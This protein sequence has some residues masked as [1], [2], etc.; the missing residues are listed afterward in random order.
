[1]DAFMTSHIEKLVVK[2]GLV[3]LQL[4]VVPKKIKALGNELKKF[5]S[6]TGLIIIIIIKNELTNV[7]TYSKELHRREQRE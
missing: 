3:I 2:F 7:M 6:S 1:M 4:F 5:C